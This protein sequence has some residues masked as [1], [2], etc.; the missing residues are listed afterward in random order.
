MSSEPSQI[1]TPTA[2]SGGRSGTWRT[3]RAGRSTDKACVT[4]SFL[5]DG[6]PSAPTPSP[7]SRPAIS[8]WSAAGRG[9]VWMTASRRVGR[10]SA[11]YRARS[12]WGDSSTM[13]AGSTTT[14]AS[15]SRPLARSTGRRLSG[16]PRP[17]RRGSVACTPAASSATARSAT[18][19]A[20]ART[21][22]VPGATSRQAWVDSAATRCGQLSRL[23]LLEV[24]GD[25]RPPHRRGRPS[26][27]AVSA[28]TR[29]A[30]STT[31]AGVR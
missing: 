8:P 1:M 3:A 2:S 14:T 7:A 13:A 18:N 20:G 5:V 17:S 6:D 25:A 15:N 27:G 23:D 24:R 28:S 21:A 10:V 11:T 31:S 29:A 19:E 12:P 30:T 9:R 22:A 26:P 4:G 16:A